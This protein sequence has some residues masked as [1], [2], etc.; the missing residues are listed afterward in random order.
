MS[1]TTIRGTAS[2]QNVPVAVD[3]PV[4]PAPGRRRRR[5]HEPAHVTPRGRRVQRGQ[6]QVGLGAQRAARRH[7]AAVHPARAHPGPAERR[8]DARARREGPA[9]GAHGPRLGLLPG[10]GRR[11]DPRAA[12][13]ARPGHRGRAGS[14]LRHLLPPRQPRRAA[15]PRPGVLR[16]PRRGRGPAAHAG[17][18]AGRRGRPRGPLHGPLPT[19]GPAGV[20]RAPHRGAAAVGAREAAGHRRRPGPRPARR[21]RRG[22]V[23]PPRGPHLADRRDPPGAPD[24]A[25][26][27]PVGRLLPRAARALRPPRGPHRV[28]RGACPRRPHASRGAPGRWC[29]ARGSAA[30]ATATPT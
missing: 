25:R 13:R 17:R 9:E 10:R 1:A 12:L 7:P 16:P 19:R 28:R 11:R 5:R 20:H 8:R 14:G 18:P 29:W 26:R 27:G 21:G 3:V 15:A 30:T 22:Q 24:R 23:A 6:R 2:V 4:R